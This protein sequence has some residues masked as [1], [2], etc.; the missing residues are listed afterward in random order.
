MTRAALHVV[1]VRPSE[2]AAA[3]ARVAAG[4]IG[5]L[6]EVYD[7]HAGAL[8][9]FARR[10]AGPADADDLLQSTFLRAA[11]TA[12]TYDG[13]RAGTARPWL[14]GIAARLVQERR[15][16]LARQARAL[17][18]VAAGALAASESPPSGPGSRMDVEAALATLPT[19]KRVVVVL[20]E[21]EGYS[22]AEIAEMLRIPIGT[23]WTRLHHARRALRACLGVTE[24]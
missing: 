2:D 13:S 10:A 15:R 7:R 23:V 17:I 16:S 12:H 4:D 9:R 5:G 19:D 22:C 3:L 6:G 20:A 24:S 21:V 18:R 8:L 11:R 14:F 1:P